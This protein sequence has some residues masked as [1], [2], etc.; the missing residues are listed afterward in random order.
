VWGGVLASCEVPVALC[1]NSF[2]RST[3]KSVTFPLFADKTAAAR[4]KC[5][6]ERHR[7]ASCEIRLGSGW[8]EIPDS[9]KYGQ[10][11]RQLRAGGKGCWITNVRVDRALLVHTQQTECLLQYV[12]VCKRYVVLIGLVPR[13][14]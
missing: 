9:G 10:G 6:V 4:V 7:K 14:F 13:S 5:A 11:R 1:L 2:N 3:S 8:S 12:K